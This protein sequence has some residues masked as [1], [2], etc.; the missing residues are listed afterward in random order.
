VFLVRAACARS[1]AH[2]VTWFR[3]EVELTKEALDEMQALAA[4]M[5]DFHYLDHLA[6]SLIVT[7]LQRLSA[8]LKK[9]RKAG[10]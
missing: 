10:K 9:R 4:N 8:R 3:L 6:A 7:V 2:V 1:A 5:D